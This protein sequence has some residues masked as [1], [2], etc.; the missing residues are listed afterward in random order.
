MD[1]RQDILNNRKSFLFYFDWD[2]YVQKMT[3]EQAGILL[4]AILDLAI[5]GV[6]PDFSSDLALELSFIGI[7]DTIVRDTD[8]YVEK[9]KRNREN[10]A[11]GGRP[12]K[13]EPTD[14][15]EKP[16]GSFG[17]PEKTEQNPE[18]PDRDIDSDSDM[19]KNRERDRDSVID[20]DNGSEDYV[21]HDGSCR[22]NVYPMFIERWN[23][24]CPS[25]IKTLSDTQKKGIDN[26]INAYNFKTMLSTID[27]I[28][29]SDYLMGNK[30]NKS[31]DVNFFLKE[32]SFQKI[33]DDFYK[34][35]Y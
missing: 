29:E 25:K 32:E 12:K 11:N 5:R 27:K 23:N 6:Y 3:D 21:F 35:K 8:K 16:N 15:P 30:S 18:K 34:N 1:I 9:C 31:I 28:Q 24:I 26:I 17:F 14:N 33:M 20:I 22:R 19:D 7:G 2:K 13:E 10:G 4:K